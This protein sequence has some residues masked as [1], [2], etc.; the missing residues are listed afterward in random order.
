[1]VHR[2]VEDAQGRW[3]PRAAAAHGDQRGDQ[4]GD[5]AA[6]ADQWYLSD[7]WVL[8]AGRVAGSVERRGGLFELIAACDAVNQ[9]IVS[10]EELE[11]GLS[12]LVGADLMIADHDGIGVT[13]RGRELV[14]RAGREVVSMNVRTRSGEDRIRALYRLLTEIPLTPEPL[15]IDRETYDAACLE[16]RHERWTEFRRPQR[17]A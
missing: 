16:Y 13:A 7:A 5:Q 15:L 11:H 17:R 4:R 9:L 14:T 12:A 10:L 1:M 6:P 3:A 2:V 8:A